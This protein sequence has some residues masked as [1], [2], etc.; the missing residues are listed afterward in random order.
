MRYLISLFLLLA[1]PGQVFAD[2]PKRLADDFSPLAGYIVL[3]VGSDEYLI[4]LDAAKGVHLGDIF[5]VLGK[6]QKII[7]PVTGEV[8]GDLDGESVFLQVTRLK[9]GFSYVRK[10][11]GEAAVKKGDKIQR[12]LSVPARYVSI[13]ADRGD[14]KNEL[15]TKLNF[16]DWRTNNSEIPAL[17]VFEQNRKALLVKNQ[18]GS[19]LFEY[20]LD[21]TKSP[22]GAS[23][24]RVAAPAASA[25]PAPG[26]AEPGKVGI[27][28]NPQDM[29]KIWHGAE[30]KDNIIGLRIDDFNQ[31]QTMETA[32]LLKSRLV[33]SVYASRSNKPIVTLSLRGG[34]DYLAIDSIDLNGNGRPEI[35]LSAVKK[36]VPV[37]VVYELDGRHLTEVARDLPIL[38]RRIDHPT[39]GAMLLGQKRLDLK[40]PFSERPFRVVFVN[41]RYQPGPAYDI[42][43]PINIYGYVPLLVENQSE[44]S[45]Y[46]SDTDYLKIKTSEGNDIYESAEHF[47]GSEVKFQLQSDERD[48]FFTTYFIPER[49]LVN[50]GE[51]LAPQN[52]GPRITSSWRHFNKSRIISL[53]W[54]GLALDEAWRTSDQAGQTADFAFADIDNDGQ[55]ELVLGVNF[56]RK[57]LFKTPKSAIVVYE[58]N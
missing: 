32:V 29:T 2:L 15:Q 10:M 7:H 22:A 34:I 12:F 24:L 6:G 39:E 55:A 11:S 41:G 14:L 40:V 31:D 23:G 1:I 48:G 38:F 4:D 43:R 56:T 30:Y 49:L 17:L 52:D 42:P 36:G 35:F 3:P 58:M 45:V 37:S 20:R 9:P 28:Q 47:G 54:N 19:V 46:L 27:I 25:L 57:G 21:G 18:D 8:I 5:T 44:Y 33:V 13:P 51:I 50:N 26:S 16:L 53:K